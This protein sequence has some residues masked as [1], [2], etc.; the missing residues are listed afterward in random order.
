M[1]NDNVDFKQNF[2]AICV[3]KAEVYMDKETICELINDL[4]DHNNLFSN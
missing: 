4:L 3:T 2:V 1:F